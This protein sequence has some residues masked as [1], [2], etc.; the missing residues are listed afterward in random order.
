MKF[1]WNFSTRT[2]IVRIS[3]YLHRSVTK[4]VANGLLERFRGKYD[5]QMWVGLC[6]WDLTIITSD[7]LCALKYIPET[8]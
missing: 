2:S 1:I 3:K 6:K 5:G 7:G 8:F 4:S